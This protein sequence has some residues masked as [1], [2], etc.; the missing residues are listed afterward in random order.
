VLTSEKFSGQSEQ[1]ANIA[2]KSVTSKL[3]DIFTP[4]ERMQ[5][6]G[7]LILSLVSAMAQAFGVVAVFPFINVVM[8][9]EVIRTNRIL[10]T[11]YLWGNFEDVTS[12]V[13]FLGI[14]V[15][16]VVVFS[17]VI[18]AAAIWANTHFVMYKNHTLSKRLLTVY[19]SKP[20][21][22]FL[23]KNTNELGMN[24]LAEVHQLTNM[25]LMGIFDLIIH[26]SILLVLV[27]M[28]LLVDAP[29]T[30]GAI[31]FLG[32]SYG[33]LNLIIKRKL[34]VSGI[35]RLE[36]NEERYRLAN[37]ALSS[38]KTTKVTGNESYFVE[39]YSQQSERFAK[40]NVFASISGELPKYILEAVAFGGIVFFIVFKILS[41]DQ[42]SDLI[43]LVSLFAFAGYRMMPALHHLYKGIVKLYFNQA[44]LDKLYRDMAAEQKE[45]GSALPVV[46][47]PEKMK[48]AERLTLNNRILMNDIEFGYED[49]SHNVIDRL[50]ISI[51]KNTSIGVVGSTGSGKT[52]LVD[53]ILGLLV[54][55]RGHIMVDDTRINN[56]NRRA[57]QQMIGY[58]P[59]E[60]YL[61]D[62]TI[63][64]NIAFGVS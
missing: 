42:I 6:T 56:V 29:I 53:I 25:Y 30:I 2:T 20:Y 1:E 12:F 60:I 41:G 27:G 24:I 43:P 44:I 19:L 58:V 47:F 36:A 23:Q 45:A 26:G 49:S 33:L 13:V 52:T 59:Q 37:E 15:F 64:N 5:I 34:K 63:R 32:G 4:R 31:V 28:L 14:G 48:S 61:S 46:N 50:T 54:P 35:E 62:N 38:I 3:Y 17:N 8:N 7:L 51:E 57:W 40:H 9:P 55:D 18:A 11:L 22:Y 39:H 16:I 10:E 21:E